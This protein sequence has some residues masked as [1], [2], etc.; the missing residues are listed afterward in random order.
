MSVKDRSVRSLT[1]LQSSASTA[2]V[3]NLLLT[4]RKHGEEDDYRRAPFFSN[5]LLNRCIIVKHRL[6]SNEL[7]LF[8]EY[9]SAATKILIPLDNTDLKMGARY[10]FVGQRSYADLLTDALGIRLESGSSD[11]RLLRIID[12]IPSLDPFLLREQLRR[13]SFNPARC[14]F[15]VSDADVTR[16]FSFAQQEIEPLV[17]MSFSGDAAMATYSAKLVSKILSSEVDNDLDPLRMT[18]QLDPQQFDEGI[19]CWKAFLYYKW[20]LSELMPQ[21]QVVIKELSTLQPGSRCDADL[22]AQIEASRLQIRRRVGL[23]LEQV[24]T[25]MNIYDTAYRE[26]TESGNARGFRD[27]L[28]AAPNLFHQLGERLAGVDHVVSFWRYRFPKDR[29]A[30]IQAEDLYDIFVDFEGGLNFQKLERAA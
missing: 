10:L 27:F 13:L 19:F 28:L 2:R 17:N 29:M 26:L 15:E 6:R 4:Y 9:R 5:H 24:R 21:L 8:D 18:L 1:K 16:M 20:Q 23:A 30:V 14:Y 11:L 22:R 3:L 12:E 7:D 25:T